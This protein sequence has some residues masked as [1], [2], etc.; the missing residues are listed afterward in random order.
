MGVNI[1]QRNLFCGPKGSRNIGQLNGT[2]ECRI[3]GVSEQRGVRI[4]AFERG[5]RTRGRRTVQ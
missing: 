4:R 1:K 5:F 3:T 2:Q